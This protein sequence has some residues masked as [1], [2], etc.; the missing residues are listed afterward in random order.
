MCDRGWTSMSRY[1]GTH[2]LALGNV[3]SG[4]RCTGLLATRNKHM[5]RQQA[6]RRSLYVGSRYICVAGELSSRPT[7]SS[8]GFASRTSRL[9]RM[10]L[11]RKEGSR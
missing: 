9:V 8:V 5:L 4:R 7:A 2:I 1:V 11:L 3:S 6:V 10:M